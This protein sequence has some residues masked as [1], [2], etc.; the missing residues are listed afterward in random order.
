MVL[1][2]IKIKFIFNKLLCP[3][4][5]LL[6]THQLGMSSFISTSGNFGYICVLH[7][8]LNDT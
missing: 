7:A 8:K 5:L 1:K 3:K 2:M 4:R 6:F